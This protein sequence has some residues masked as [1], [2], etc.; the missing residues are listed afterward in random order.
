MKRP[1]GVP[2]SVAERFHKEQPWMRSEWKTAN[3]PTPTMDSHPLAQVMASSSPELKPPEMARVYTRQSERSRMNQN[4][5]GDTTKSG[6]AIS[7]G[8]A[9]PNERE[10]G[11][12]P[13]TPQSPK[14]VQDRWSWTNSQAP[15]TPRFH[16]AP[17]LHSSLSSLPRFKRVTSWVR[18]QAERQT[19]RIDEERP[20]PSRTISVPML[21]NK[22]SKP[23]LA[24]KPT[25]KLSKKKR[26]ESSRS[27][28]FQ[29]SS[30]TAGPVP[31]TSA[32]LAEQWP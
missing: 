19:H 18:G 25:R 10:F 9:S 31:P 17:S 3:P 20:P 5:S 23:T 4:S 27:Q 24:P 22:A 15:P 28:S 6:L 21:K 29:P 7:I 32:R 26:P 8:E 1:S 12:P 30:E 16:A 13:E 11:P 14:D 2:A